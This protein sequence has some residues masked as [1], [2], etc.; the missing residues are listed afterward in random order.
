MKHAS[1]RPRFWTDKRNRVLA[2][3]TASGTCI[4]DISAAIGATVPAIKR[5][6]ERLNIN[7]LAITKLVVLEIEARLW[8]LPPD[9]FKDYAIP[10]EA[11][12]TAFA[13]PRYS[14]K[15]WE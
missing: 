13:P 8:N 2:E 9:A 3:M 6:R 12:Y 5:Q 11:R 7:P 14:K 1:H 15:G 10:R 4:E